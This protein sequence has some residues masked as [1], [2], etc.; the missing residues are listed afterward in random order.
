MDVSISDDVM[1]SDG[2]V[3]LH[4][5]VRTDNKVQPHRNSSP[6]LICM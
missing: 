2:L 1:D 3:P 6:S 5:D 4:S